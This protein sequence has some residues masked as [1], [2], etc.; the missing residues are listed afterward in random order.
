M[1]DLLDLYTQPEDPKRPLVCFD[2]TS[3]A[4]RDHCRPLILV[5][6]GQPARYDYEYERR[7]TCNLFMLSAPLRGWR[8]VCVRRRRTAVD[9]A[10]VLKELAEVHFPEAETIVLVCDNLNTHTPK[11]LYKAFDQET[12]ARLE[13]RFEW[14]YTPA[15]G[16]WLN[17]AECELSVLARQCL[18][19]RFPEQDQ[20]AAEVAPGAATAT[21]T[22]GPSA[23]ASRPHRPASSCAACTHQPNPACALSRAAAQRA[24]SGWSGHGRRAHCRTARNRGTPQRAPDGRRSP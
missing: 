10:H 8:E 23:G 21:R 5:R 20:V 1:E 17:L 12:A 19:R 9:C 24:R 22:P 11:S 4:L 2:E 14:H 18:N 3:K 7:G 6:P 13:A 15:H 16:S